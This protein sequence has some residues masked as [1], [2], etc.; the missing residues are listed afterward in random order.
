MV[1]KVIITKPEQIFEQGKKEKEKLEM[2]G[3]ERPLCELVLYVI[4]SFMVHSKTKILRSHCGVCVCVC[5]S[6]Y[7]FTFFFPLWDC[8]AT[9][10][11]SVLVKKLSILITFPRK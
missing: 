9:M 7:L 8:N 4:T 10:I 2:Y 3:R 11:Y 1:R 5:I 6:M